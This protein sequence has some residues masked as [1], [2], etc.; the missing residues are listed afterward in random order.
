MYAFLGGYATVYGHAR[1]VL[2]IIHGCGGS[3]CLDVILFSLLRGVLARLLIS[4]LT[5]FKKAVLVVGVFN[6]AASLGGRP[7]DA[8]DDM[9]M[10]TKYLDDCVIIVMV[11]ILSCPCTFLTHHIAIPNY[12]AFIF[13]STRK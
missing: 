2:F 6:C 10:V 11:C 5:L 1:L 4:I 8:V 9:L 12:D 13:A 7:D 3:F